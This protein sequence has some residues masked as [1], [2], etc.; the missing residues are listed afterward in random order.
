[1]CAGSINA[2]AKI[3]GWLGFFMESRIGARRT[4]WASERKRAYIIAQ[5]KSD[6][7]GAVNCIE[8]KSFTNF[9]DY[10]LWVELIELTL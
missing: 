4:G 9:V 1:M 7:G 2:T 5:S 6:K 3:R 8:K 10:M